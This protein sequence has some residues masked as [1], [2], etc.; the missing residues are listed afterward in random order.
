MSNEQIKN[1]RN[2][3]RITQLGRIWVH[4]YNHNKLIST[5]IK[6]ECLEEYLANGYI[7]GRY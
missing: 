1:W 6:K 4:K 3:I 2:N 7:K 5:R